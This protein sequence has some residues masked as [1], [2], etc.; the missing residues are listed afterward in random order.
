MDPYTPRLLNEGL[1][2]MIGKGY[3]SPEVIRAIVRNK[4]VYFGASGGLG[5]LLSD[6]IIKKR[7]VAFEDLGTEAIFEL[8]VKDFPVIVVIDSEG[9]NLYETGRR[10]YLLFMK[11]RGEL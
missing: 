3:R 8:E 5:V 11:E 2:G 9:N 6:K 4:A 10:D 7:T 1:S